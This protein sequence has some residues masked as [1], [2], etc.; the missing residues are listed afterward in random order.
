MTTSKGSPVYKFQQLYK[1]QS[2]DLIAQ[3]TENSD[4]DFRVTL[5][6]NYNPCTGTTTAVWHATPTPT[7]TPTA[8]PEGQE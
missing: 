2:E 7:P 1:L 3:P 4:V 5:G 6:W 8:T